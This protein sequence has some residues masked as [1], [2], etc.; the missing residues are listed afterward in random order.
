[1]LLSKSVS[2]SEKEN[3]NEESAVFP[4]VVVK[5]AKHQLKLANIISKDAK[6]KAAKHANR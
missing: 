2:E 6:G 1:L 5:P 4:C 3:V